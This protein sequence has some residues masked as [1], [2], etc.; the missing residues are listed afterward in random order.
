M[1]ENISLKME[2][3]FAASLNSVRIF[4]YCNIVYN[5]ENELQS[6]QTI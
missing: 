5:G 2:V 4:V 1:S 6:T 3:K